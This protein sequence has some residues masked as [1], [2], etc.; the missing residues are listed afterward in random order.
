[1][2]L[3]ARQAGKST[4]AQVLAGDRVPVDYLTLDD[5]PVRAVARAD[6]QR[7]VAALGRRTVIGV[8]RRSATP[9]PFG[10]R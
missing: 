5:D 7:S 9:Q 3:H 2:A 8:A 1:V 6:P 4:L 10:T